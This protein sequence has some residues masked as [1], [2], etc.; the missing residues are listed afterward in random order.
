M[1]D[2]VKNPWNLRDILTQRVRRRLAKDAAM[3]AAS[4]DGEDPWN[5]ETNEEDD[6]RVHAIVSSLLSYS[7]DKG[8]NFAQQFYLDSDEEMF[9]E[10]V[11]AES[12]LI[13]RLKKERL[14]PPQFTFGQQAHAF[15]QQAHAFGQQA[16]TFGQ[17]AQAFGQQVQ[18][19]GSS[20]PQPPPAFGSPPQS[21]LDSSFGGIPPSLSFTYQDDASSNFEFGA[22]SSSE[23]ENGAAFS[24]GSSRTTSRLSSTAATSS[25]ASS[26][27]RRRN[28][29]NKK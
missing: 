20:P 1:M 7:I 4:I 16:Q 28:K 6:E 8:K 5:V 25:T 3:L 14:E 29:T 2:S 19:F 13:S 26:R 23:E 21:G 22:T 9:S 17:Q 24:F 27:R 15:G 11:R 10:L 12:R 18:A